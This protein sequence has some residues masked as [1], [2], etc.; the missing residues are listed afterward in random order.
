MLRY[1]LDTNICI[2]VMK[3]YPPDLRDK[4]NS[5]ADELCISSITLGELYY[6]AET[7][8]RR[9]DNLNAVENFCARLEVLPFAE[10]AASHYGQIRAELARAGTPCGAH[11]MQIGG[12]ARSEGL[13]VVTNNMREFVRMP[14]LRV[15][16][17]V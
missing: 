8:A 3:T 6:G 13:I 16:N 2:Y 1:M 10:K 17:W 7:S 9:H 12:H 11:D 14:G 4:F 15:E 5:L